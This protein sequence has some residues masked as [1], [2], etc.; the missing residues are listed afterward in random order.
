M[1]AA[2]VTEFGA[3]GVFALTE[4]PDPVPGPGQLAID[5]SHA[6][7]GLIDVY[8]RQ[9]LYKDRE[10]LPQPPYVPGLEVAGTVRAV[11]AGVA[12]F[13]IGEPVVTLSGTGAEGGYASIAVVDAAL[14]ARLD[15]TGVDPA[16]AVAAVPNA[17][18]AFLALTEVAHLKPGERLLVHGALGGLASTFPGVARTLGAAAVVGTVRRSSLAAARASALPY[19]EIVAGEDLLDVVGRQRF[20]VVV[21]PVGGRLR[22]D[23]L[24]VMA[25]MGR[26]LLVGN[27]S[28]D[29]EHTVPTN[30]L[31]FGSLA[32]LGFSIGFYLPAHPEQAAPAAR[33]A[34][35]AIG[36][37]LVDIT[38]RTLPLAEAAEAHRLVEQGSVRGRILLAP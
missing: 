12:G 28:G 2:V 11:G 9:G 17:A 5:V 6:A 26:M 37:G 7:V 25:P 13:R 34:V 10:G 33:G 36:Q 23:S 4:L 8:I 29:W 14:T 18:T 19:D 15:G 35:E 1:H 32:L 27:A 3:P 16:V 30:S 21:D 22:T 38:T 24:Q 20:D 31:W